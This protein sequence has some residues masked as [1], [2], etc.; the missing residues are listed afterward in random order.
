VNVLGAAWSAGRR[1]VWSWVLSASLAAALLGWALRGVEWRQVASA[2][3]R[4]RWGFLAAAAATSGCSLFLRA[5]RWRILLN[6]SGRFSVWTVFWANNAGYLGNNFLPARAGEFIRSVLLSSRSS[7]SKTY[8]LATALS[9]RL[10]DAIAL[11]LGS[12]LLFLKVRPKPPGM[13]DL[14]R[15]LAVAACLGALALAILPHSGRWLQPILNRIPMPVRLRETLLGLAAQALSGVGAL[16]AGSRFASFA[17]LTGIIWLSDAVGV[18]AVGRALHL[19]LPLSTA[20]LVLAGLGLGSALPSTPGYI[21]I[22]QFVAVT[23]LP[24]FGVTRDNAVAFI[25][26]LQTLGYAVVLAFGLM[27]IYRLQGPKPEENGL[28]IDSKKTPGAL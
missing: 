18:M 9:E 2:I 7:L 5:L 19:P 17:G 26:V 12:S 25:L 20:F 16:H 4:A 21:G 15:M 24:P 27:G 14:S 3:S 1:S 6:A 23:V 11:I 13:E 10:M 28:R 22:Y 8:V